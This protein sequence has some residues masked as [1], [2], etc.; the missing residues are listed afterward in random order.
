MGVLWPVSDQPKMRK[1][2]PEGRIESVD[3]D[4][5]IDYGYLTEPGKVPVEVTGLVWWTAPA[6]RAAASGF[7]VRVLDPDEGYRTL[8]DTLR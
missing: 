1:A 5:A 7:G 4:H 6:G 8:L 2:H 3:A